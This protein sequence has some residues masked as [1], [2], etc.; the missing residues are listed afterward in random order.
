MTRY[1]YPRT[2]H[3][4]FSEGVGSDDKILKDLTH[5]I[6]NHC[7]VTVKM[8]GEN[9][10][11]ARDY[12]H[13]RSIDSK[14]HESRNHIKQLQANIGYM[15]GDGQRICGE[16]IY[17]AHSIE[18]SDLK[19][20]FYGVSF[21]EEKVCLDWEK[22]LIKFDKLSITPVEVLFEGIVTIEILKELSK[23]PRF[24]DGSD[25]G[26]VVRPYSM[27]T[28]DG[29]STHVVK[30]VRKGH[31]QTDKHWMHQEVKVNKVLTTTQ[32]IV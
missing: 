23:L 2:F 14:H 12:S 11:I 3:L 1:K 28:Y 6:D 31:V 4:P 10:T 29:F 27:F 24:H 30:W 22:T 5:I 25:E 16:N 32:I 21:W 17:A 20:Y 26:F 19:S 9:S 15:L 7:V 8:D 13:A 18:Y